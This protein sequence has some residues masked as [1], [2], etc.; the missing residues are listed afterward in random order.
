VIS[1]GM[2]KAWAE[3]VWAKLPKHKALRSSLRIFKR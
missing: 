3:T 1:R 2:Y